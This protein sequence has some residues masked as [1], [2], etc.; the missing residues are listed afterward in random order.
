MKNTVKVE[1]LVSPD[2]SSEKHSHRELLS[3]LVNI[4]Q[5]VVLKKQLACRKIVLKSLAEIPPIYLS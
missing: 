5:P 2:Y 3:W 1:V 4:L